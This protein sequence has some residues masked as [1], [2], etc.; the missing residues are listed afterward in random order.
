MVEDPVEQTGEEAATNAAAR[1]LGRWK[2]DATFDLLLVIARER[3]LAGAIEVLAEYG[4]TEAIPA[5]SAAL[6]EDFTRPAAEEG[7]RRLGRAGR[8]EL[9]RL[10]RTHPPAATGESE[11]SRR[12]RRAALR[13]LAE[14]SDSEARPD[15]VLIPLINDP[16]PE[17]ACRAAFLILPALPEERRRAVALRLLTLRES[18]DWHVAEA[19][20]AALARLQQLEAEGHRRCAPD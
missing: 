9:L 18:R 6:A 4:R 2:D 7:F 1:A 19:A 3:P 15:P 16:D 17:V 14:V 13:L 8:P 11:S 5:F 20:E 10:A 12:L